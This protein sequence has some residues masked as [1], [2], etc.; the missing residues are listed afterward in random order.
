[1][2][3]N[4]IVLAD[5]NQSILEGLRGLL[6]TLFEGVVMVADQPSLIEAL[7]KIKPKIAVVDLSL[8][9]NGELSTASE[10]HKHFPDIKII[11]LSDYDESNIAAEVM[12]AGVSGFVIK[13]Y[14]GTDL[15]DAIQSVQT[16]QTYVSP[17]VK[18]YDIQK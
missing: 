10:F 15:F 11:I 17:A 12:S 4:C 6:E 18:K 14:A 2:E 7:N 8:L 1:M 5:K 13:R 3:S 9:G 16:G